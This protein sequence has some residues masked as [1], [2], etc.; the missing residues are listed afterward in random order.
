MFIIEITLCSRMMHI[1]QHVYISFFFSSCCCQV[2]PNPCLYVT[3]LHFQ[4]LSK[5]PMSQDSPVSITTG[6]ALDDQDVGVRVPVRSRIFFSPSHPDQLWGPPNLLSD[7]YQGLFS[8]GVKRPGREAD[9]L[10]PRSRKCG[11]I[12][13]LPDTPSWCC[14]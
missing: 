11:S 6:Y 8:P 13:P 2:T 7:G 10:V 14:A 9:Q 5:I 1:C 4:F 12:H 3:P